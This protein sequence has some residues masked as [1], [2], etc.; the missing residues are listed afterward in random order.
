MEGEKKKNKCIKTFREE[1][2]YKRM[3]DRLRKEL[4]K[5]R[6]KNV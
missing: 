4:K 6:E 2:R 1:G 3:E 5:R